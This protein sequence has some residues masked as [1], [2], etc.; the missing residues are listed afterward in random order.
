MCGLA[1]CHGACAALQT[2]RR[3][4]EA[5]VRLCTGGRRADATDALP[6]P[7]ERGCLSPAPA[8]SL[9]EAPGTLHIIARHTCY[10]SEQRSR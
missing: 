4:R 6:P 5:L 2:A 7:A 8:G 10:H 3:L 1:S 9:V